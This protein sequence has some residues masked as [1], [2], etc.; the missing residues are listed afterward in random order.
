MEKSLL[1][2]LT[3]FALLFATWLVL[4]GHFSLFFIILGIVSCLIATA[5][6]KIS[7]REKITGAGIKIFSLVSY[8]LWLIKEIVKSSIDVSLLMWKLDPEIS[9]QAEWV[10]HDLKGDNATVLFA[11]SITLTP[12]TVTIDTKKGAL[13]VHSL[14]KDSIVDLKKGRMLRLIKK[15]LKS[16]Q[17]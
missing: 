5:L 8:F 11:N 7:Y 4:S 6:Y 16:R 10:K 13:F 2:A 17:K 15:T 14:T 1:N 3:I 12:G 9:P